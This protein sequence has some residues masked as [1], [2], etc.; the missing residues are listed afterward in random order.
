[1]IYSNDA[2]KPIQWRGIVVHCSGSD[3]EEDAS[4]QAI[5]FLHTS[6]PY[7]KIVWGQYHTCGKGY[8]DIA[9]QYVI[10]TRGNIWEVRPLY[11]IGAHAVGYNSTH[12][13][14]CVCGDQRF[15]PFQKEALNLLINNL[16]KQF[17]ISEE[18]VIPHSQVSNKGKTCPNFDL[19]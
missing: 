18:E 8:D 1:M 6:P 10:D 13:G 5:H 14:I 2:R 19:K 17:N 9:Y 16:K 7:R 3:L 15:N 12:I 11:K 4:V